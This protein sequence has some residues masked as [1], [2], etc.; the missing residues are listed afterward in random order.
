MGAADLQ[1]PSLTEP[2][3]EARPPTRPPFDRRVL[4]GLLAILLVAG[5]VAVAIG[6]SSHSSQPL[7]GGVHSAK[8]ASF[9]GNE[10]NPPKP[11]PEL[12]LHNYL[13][14]AP[15]SLASFRGKAVFV[16]FL[17][18]HCPDVCP[19]ITANLHSAQSLMGTR[20]AA[21]T[22]IIAVSVDPR[23]DTRRS[24]AAF[25]KE[26]DMTGRMLYLTGSA[27][28][29]GRVW[30]AWKVGSQRDAQQ[31]EFINHSAIVFGIDASGTLRTIYDG[32]GLKP[33]EV[34]HDAPLLAGAR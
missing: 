6:G 15:V 12:G 25:L 4:L 27:S 16:T 23:G 28:E 9:L 33:A 32:N 3:R 17:Y 8:S 2:S 20:G 14:G 26:H 11:A 18:T 34:A 10:L 13:G 7:P 29:L 19:L 5:A 22:Q 31:P 30:E 1:D 24:V 21:K